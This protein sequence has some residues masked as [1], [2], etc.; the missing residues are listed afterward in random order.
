LERRYPRHDDDHDQADQEE[1]EGDN[2]A[3]HRSEVK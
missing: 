2:G 3:E 1:D